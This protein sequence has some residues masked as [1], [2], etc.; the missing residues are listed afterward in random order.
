MPVVPGTRH[1]R[2]HPWVRAVGISTGEQ[3]CRRACRRLPRSAG[4][5]CRRVGEGVA[6]GVPGVPGAAEGAATKVL[7]T[8]FVSP[9]EANLMNGAGVNAALRGLPVGAGGAQRAG[10][11]GVRYGFRYSV[12]ARPPSA[13]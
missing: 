10:N 11:L 3:A 8:S 7:S 5:R 6:G 12:L 9:G 2:S 4:F 13:G 1:P